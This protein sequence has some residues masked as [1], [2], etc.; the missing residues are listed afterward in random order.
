M[1][2]FLCGCCEHYHSVS[3]YGDCR[4]DTNRFTADD[5]DRLFPGWDEVEIYVDSVD[6]QLAPEKE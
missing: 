5:L 1:K 4:D 6:D 3:F 2:F